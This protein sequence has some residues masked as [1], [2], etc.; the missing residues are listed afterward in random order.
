[1]I[2]L[3][4]EIE[5]FQWSTPTTRAR[6]FAA[7]RVRRL[8]TARNDAQ[9]A[10]IEHGNAGIYQMPGGHVIAEYQHGEIT[11]TETVG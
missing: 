6:R 5:I 7:S 11:Y 4:Y 9:N 8:A 1:M 2:K 3:W 10:S